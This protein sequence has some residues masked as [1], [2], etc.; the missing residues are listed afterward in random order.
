MAQASYRYYQVQINKTVT[1]HK[2]M[3][4]F[5][6]I[7]NAITDWTALSRARG[8]SLLVGKKISQKEYKDK[9]AQE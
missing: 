7:G 2:A 5:G 4:V 9:H 6:A 1:Y 8:I 3:T